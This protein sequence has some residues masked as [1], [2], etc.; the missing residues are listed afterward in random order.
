MKR[1]FMCKN[2]ITRDLLILFIYN[3][4]SI[5]TLFAHI[6]AGT[7]GLSYTFSWHYG[8]TSQFSPT[9]FMSNSLVKVAAS[10]LRNYINPLIP[11]H[12]QIRSQ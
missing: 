6:V 4:L 9:K 5:I 8:T 2:L 7:M 3:V 11:K 12:I 1:E 10:L